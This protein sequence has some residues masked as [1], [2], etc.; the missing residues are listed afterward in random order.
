MGNANFRRKLPLLYPNIGGT[1]LS[2]ISQYQAAGNQTY[3]G[4]LL[5]IQRRAARGVTVSSNY[6]LSHCYGDDATKESQAGGPG[7]TYVDPNNRNFDRGNCEGDRRHIFNMTVVAQTPQFANPM[8]HRLATGWRL[9]GLYRKSS[10]AWL[11]VTSGQDRA[12][13]GV[14]N[15]RALQILGNP[16]GNKSLTNYLNP[17]AFVLP[18]AGSYG[19]MGTNSI[20]GP[21]TWQFDASLVRAFPL[22]ENQRLEARIEA[23]NVT[24]SF[25]PGVGSPSTNVG[26]PVTNLSSGN[27]GQ[28]NLA[29]DPRLL[30]FALKYVF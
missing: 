16:Y 13:T 27:F 11:T 9:S 2:F 6:T 12:L 3:N 23:F 25:R 8:L 14:S 29:L 28:I 24:N 15:Q 19:N 20:Q 22:R 10:G 30:Q 7:S 21:G 26:A 5:S 17:A 1:T 18:A 4:M